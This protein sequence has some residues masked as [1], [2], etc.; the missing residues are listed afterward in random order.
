MALGILDFCNKL[1][2]KKNMTREFIPVKSLKRN[3]QICWKI[4][5]PLL[6]RKIYGWSFNR[7]TYKER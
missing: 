4:I 2:K 3:I 1:K 7:E 6:Y 5:N